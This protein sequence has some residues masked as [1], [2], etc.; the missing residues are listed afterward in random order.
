MESKS[1]N[2][3]S[4]A[5]RTTV[6]Q[7]SAVKQPREVEVVVEDEVEKEEGEEKEDEEKG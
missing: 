2:A 6:V 5:K 4:Q 1:I 3:A 7:L